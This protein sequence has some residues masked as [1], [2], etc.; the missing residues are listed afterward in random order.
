M[1]TAIDIIAAYDAEIVRLWG[2]KLAR[3]WPHAKDKLFADRWLAAGATVDLCK[4]VFAECLERKHVQRE[5][6]PTCLSY[7]ENP[8][9]AAI[10]RAQ[11]PEPDDPDTARWRARVQGWQR[12]PVLWREESWGFAPD[13]VH[14]RCPK[15]VLSALGIK[16]Q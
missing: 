1:T 3:C 4:A 16:M 5:P 14:T 8:V 15:R 13:H 6:Y 7:F 12:N 2:D 11:A 10:I 9:K